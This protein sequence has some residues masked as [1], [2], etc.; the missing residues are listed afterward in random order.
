MNGVR[1]GQ[2]TYHW[3]GGQKYEGGWVNDMREGEGV[4]TWPGD[5]GAFAGS[6]SRNKMHG[7]GTHTWP[8]GKSCKEEWNNG[9]LV[10]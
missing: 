9:K 7:H 8:D 4:L 1:C 6:F 3:R 10:R 2:G 5:D